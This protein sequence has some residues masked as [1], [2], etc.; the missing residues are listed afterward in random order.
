M[1][2]EL[3]FIGSVLVVGIMLSVVSLG[4]YAGYKSNYK[5]CDNTPIICK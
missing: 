5:M 3:Y 4:V 1:R 2:N